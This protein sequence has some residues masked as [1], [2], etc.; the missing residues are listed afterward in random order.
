MILYRNASGRLAGINPAG[1]I[2]WV[3]R[4]EGVIVWT[5]GGDRIAVDM[6][7]GDWVDAIRETT[8]ASCIGIDELEGRC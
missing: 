6:S 8:T 4:E 5:I 1:I 3:A 7:E 2:R